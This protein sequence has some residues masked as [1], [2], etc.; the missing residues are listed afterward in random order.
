MSGYLLSL[1]EYLYQPRLRIFHENT[2]KDINQYN[3]TRSRNIYYLLRL[4]KGSRY[5]LY[6]KCLIVPTQYFGQGQLFKVK[7]LVLVQTQ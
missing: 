4:I 1:R 2:H 7:R 5:T 3:A 6:Q